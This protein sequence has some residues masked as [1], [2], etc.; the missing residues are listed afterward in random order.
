MSSG[1]D[2]GEHQLGRSKSSGQVVAEL[3]RLGQDAI[4][5]GGVRS[6]CLRAEVGQGGQG[7]DPSGWSD[8][9]GPAQFGRGLLQES[10]KTR[11]DIGGQWNRLTF[12]REMTPSIGRTVEGVVEVASG[13]IRSRRMR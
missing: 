5:M 2:L 1:L 8:G 3:R 11:E 7:G 4:D 12:W 10:G 6:G 9:L 13:S